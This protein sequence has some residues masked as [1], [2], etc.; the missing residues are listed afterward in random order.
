M[1][2]L[3]F[4][5]TLLERSLHRAVPSGRTVLLTLCA[6]WLALEG[7]DTLVPIFSVSPLAALALAALVGADRGRAAFGTVAVATG[8]DTGGG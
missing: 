6:L 7:L 8:S 2:Q 4:L 1:L 3:P 5:Q